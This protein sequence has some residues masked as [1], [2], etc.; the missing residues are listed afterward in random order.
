MITAIANAVGALFGTLK[1]AVDERYAQLYDN[2]HRE[3]LKELE[4]ILGTPDCPA[5]AG[6]IGAW[7]ERVCIDAGIPAG[8]ISGNTIQL[9]ISHF[10][11][12]CAIASQGIRDRQNLAKMILKVK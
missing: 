12:L 10:R 6:R 3:R 2:Q 1:P 5:R 11:A 9:P 4:K 7:V 8:D